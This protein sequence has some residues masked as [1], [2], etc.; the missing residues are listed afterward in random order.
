[1][2]LDCKRLIVI[3][4]LTSFSLFAG[5]CLVEIKKYE[6]DPQPLF[7]DAEQEVENALK[8]TAGRKAIPNDLHILV[9]EKGSRQLIRIRI[10]FWILIK[11]EDKEVDINVPGDFKDRP[12]ANRDKIHFTLAELKKMGPGVVLNVNDDDDQVMVWLK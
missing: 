5:G 1:M 10:P 7:A 3:A 2:L 8:Q 6:K 4:L 11:M 9:Y 12:W